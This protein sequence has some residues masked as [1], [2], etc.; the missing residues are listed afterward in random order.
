MR[1][2]LVFSDVGRRQRLKEAATTRECQG[3]PVNT[4]N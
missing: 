3:L 1:R 4:R 2:G